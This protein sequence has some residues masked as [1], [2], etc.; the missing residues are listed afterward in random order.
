[1]AVFSRGSAPISSLRSHS[2][3]SLTFSPISSLLSCCRFGSPSRKRMRSISRSACFISSTDSS[4]SWRPSFSSPQFRNM[5]ECR[6]YW[7]IDVSSF[8]RTALRCSMTFLS[9]CMRRSFTRDEREYYPPAAREVRTE[10]GGLKNPG[11]TGSPSA[12]RIA[13]AFARAR[14]AL[15][16]A[17]AHTQFAL[18]IVERVGAGGGRLADV[19]IGDA[20]ADADVH[21]RSGLV[22]RT[23][24]IYIRAVV[25][26]V[27]PFGLDPSQRGAM[28]KTR[29]ALALAAAFAAPAFAQQPT[30]EQKLQILQQEIDELKAQS[31][32]APPDGSTGLRAGATSIV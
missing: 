11:E 3:A 29:S 19:A 7:L 4:Y 15:A 31:R 16:A 21:A 28:R 25:K 1:M 24:L 20:V 13:Q 23:I 5:R 32:S 9:P 12:G 27:G 30:V 26:R 8:V 10:S 14:G 6:K 22:M 18:Q 2:S 17:R